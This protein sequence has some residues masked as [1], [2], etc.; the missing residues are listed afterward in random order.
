MPRDLVDGKS[1][2]VRIMAWRH[3]AIIWTNI[4]HDPRRHMTSLGHSELGSKTPCQEILRN[5]IYM[6]IYDIHLMD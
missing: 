3:Q 5:I 2:W 6:Q 4:G 1:T